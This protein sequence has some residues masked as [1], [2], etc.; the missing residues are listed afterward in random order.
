M[1]ERNRATPSGTSLS[2]TFWTIISYSWHF[3]L[4]HFV[5]WRFVRWHFVRGILS[6]AFCPWRFVRVAFYPD[7][8]ANS[9]ETYAYTVIHG[10]S[11]QS[12]FHDAND[13]R[14][15]IWP[16]SATEDSGLLF[17]RFCLYWWLQRRSVLGDVEAVVKLL[18]ASEAAASRGVV[19]VLSRSRH[20]ARKKVLPSS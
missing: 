16:A 9:S 5:L 10:R 15:G 1:R 8:T 3:V 13:D 20:Y 18:V 4:W 11:S 2:A 17:L 6:V 14:A 7:T 12:A 19:G